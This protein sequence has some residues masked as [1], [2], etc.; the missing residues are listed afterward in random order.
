MLGRFVGAA[1]SPPHP[2]RIMSAARDDDG[3]E[4]EGRRELLI[5]DQRQPV[6]G[7]HRL[8]PIGAMG[9]AVA[10]TLNEVH[11]HPELNRLRCV[12]LQK[13]QQGETGWRSPRPFG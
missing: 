4:P 11:Q 13:Q 8:V 2:K 12:G 3:E 10:R 5:I 6:L 1:I 9:Q 7:R